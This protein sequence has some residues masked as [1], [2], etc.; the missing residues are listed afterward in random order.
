MDYVTL[1]QIIEDIDLDIIYASSD[2]DNIKIYSSEINRP[3]L[4]IVGYFEKFVPER[5][6][7]LGSAEWHYYEELPDTLRYDSLDKLFAYPIPALIISRDLPIFPETIELAKKHNKTILRSQESTSKVINKLISYIDLQLA[8]E[9]RVHGVLVEVYGV[10]VLITGKSGVGKSETALDLVIRGHRLISDD[11]VI[12]K[13]V[14]DRLMGKSPK[15][16]RHF[17]EIRGLGILDIERLYG[18]GSVKNDEFIELVIELEIWDESK[19]YDRIGLDESFKEILGI[20]V[21]TATVP[22]R[23]GRNVAM[24][25][26]VAVRNYRQKRLGYNAAF[27]LN[28]RIKNHIKSKEDKAKGR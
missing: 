16:T 23:P 24:I 5:I 1:R 7:I 2:I 25:I 17:M 19:E 3:G 9:T 6:Q 11:T 15:L 21:S 18:V 27:E 13:K 14:E 22:V 26:E 10:G 4:Q 12:I 28:E 20:E 8:P